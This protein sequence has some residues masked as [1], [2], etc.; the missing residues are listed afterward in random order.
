VPPLCCHLRED[1]YGERAW[2]DQTVGMVDCRRMEELLLP[3]TPRAFSCPA[4]V[5][6]LSSVR[7]AP[8]PVNPTRTPRRRKTVGFPPLFLVRYTQSQA[9]TSKPTSYRLRALINRR[10]ASFSILVLN[11]RPRP[12]SP[13]LFLSPSQTSSPLESIP[14]CNRNPPPIHR[15]H[16]HLNHRLLH[17]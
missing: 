3:S 1:G 15:N 12:L 11:S 16:G 9:Q 10:I 2:R 14:S 6:S 17:G 7:P 8:R 4:L 5:F 13:S